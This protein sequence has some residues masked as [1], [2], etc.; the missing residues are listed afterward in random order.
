VSISAIRAI[1]V[2]ALREIWRGKGQQRRDVPDLCVP[3]ARVE[4]QGALD[5]SKRIEVERIAHR[6]RRRVF[7]NVFD[8]HGSPWIYHASSRVRGG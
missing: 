5:S 1:S 3:F 8:S 4:C 6:E 7:D 2:Q